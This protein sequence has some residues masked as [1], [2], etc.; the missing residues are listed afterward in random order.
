V[1]A[2]DTSVAKWHLFRELEEAPF[3]ATDAEGLRMVGLLRDS[4]PGYKQ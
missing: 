4:T 1:S 3:G 2:A